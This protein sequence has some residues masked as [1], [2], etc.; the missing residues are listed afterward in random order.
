M[1]KNICLIY[2]ITSRSEKKFHYA[3]CLQWGCRLKKR[4]ILVRLCLLLIFGNIFVLIWGYNIL[5]NWYRWKLKK[6]CL[7][8]IITS[9]P[10]KEFCWP[11]FSQWGCRLKKRLILV[12][13]CLLF[14]FGNIFVL[15]WGNNIL[16]NWY[17]WKLK[18]ICLV[19]IMTSRPYKEF[20]WPECFQWGCRAKKPCFLVGLCLLLEIYV[21]FVKNGTLKRP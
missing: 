4:L 6:I 18:K 16:K 10:Y 17:R 1:L 13:L 12:G 15:I 20:C 11:E 2:I 3:K 14:I 19:P 21:I 5:K 9:R 8:S 7:V